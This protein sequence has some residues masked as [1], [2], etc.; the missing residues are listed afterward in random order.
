LTSIG[1]GKWAVYSLMKETFETDF[2]YDQIGY[3]FVNRAIVGQKTT[4]NGLYTENIH[5]F[6]TAKKQKGKR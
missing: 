5:V 2:V 3:D 1:A 6:K 4:D